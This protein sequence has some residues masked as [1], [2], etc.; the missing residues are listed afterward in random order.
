[1]IQPGLKSLAIGSFV[2]L[3]FCIQAV[4]AQNAKVNLSAKDTAEVRFLNNRK[5]Y[6]YQVGK[7]E[8]LFSISQKFGIPRTSC[9]N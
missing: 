5:F 1:M 8:S 7:G 4:S 2:F 3:L 6:L 9:K